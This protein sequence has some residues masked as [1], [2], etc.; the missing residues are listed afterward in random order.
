MINDEEESDTSYKDE[1]IRKYLLNVW[2]ES[3]I[4]DF[5]LF[6]ERFRKRKSNSL[7]DMVIL[8]SFK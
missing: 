3:E 2:K 4:D 1:L 6:L 7:D 5:R 8:K